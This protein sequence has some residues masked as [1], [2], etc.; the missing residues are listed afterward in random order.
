MWVLDRVEKFCRRWQSLT[1]LTNFWWAK[2][3][4]V[5]WIVSLFPQIFDLLTAPRRI[6]KLGDDWLLVLAGGAVLLSAMVIGGILQYQA[7]ARTFDELEEYYLSGTDIAHPKTF[8]WRMYDGTMRLAYLFGSIFFLLYGNLTFIGGGLS[9][10]VMGVGFLLG[11][12]GY[13]YCA[14]CIPLPPGKSKV[15]QLLDALHARLVPVPTAL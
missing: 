7:L 9:W 6:A 2:L 15:R 11:T 10:N 3:L 1:G 8:K 5:C 13:L 4:R 14:A 12:A